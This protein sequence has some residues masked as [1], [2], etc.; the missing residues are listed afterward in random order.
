[1]LDLGSRI[2]IFIRLRNV[3]LQ[4]RSVCKD[5]FTAMELAAGTIMGAVLIIYYETSM[6]LIFSTTMT[7]MIFVVIMVHPASKRTEQNPTTSLSGVL[8][9]VSQCNKGLRDSA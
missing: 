1:M 9:A 4:N 3:G 5:C 6:A 2:D 7:M 8:E